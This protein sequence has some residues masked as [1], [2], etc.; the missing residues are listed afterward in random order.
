MYL[1]PCTALWKCQNLN[2]DQQEKYE[3]LLPLDKTLE[4][5]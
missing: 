1:A 3:E 2:G 5:S 4:V